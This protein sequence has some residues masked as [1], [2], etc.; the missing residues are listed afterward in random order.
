[1]RLF[2]LSN[3]ACSLVAIA[4]MCM[5]SCSDDE[6]V[7]TPIAQPSIQVTQASHNS[8]TFEWTAVD[9]AVQYGYKF[10]DSM[11]ELLDGGVTNVTSVSFTGLSLLSEYT[12]HVWAYPTMADEAATASDEAILSYTTPFFT[13]LNNVGVY[14]SAVVPNG[15]YDA[16]IVEERTAQD[17]FGT[18]T[19]KNFYG[20]EGYDLVFTVNA[21]NTINIL[22]GEADEASGMIKVMTGNS[23]VRVKSGLLIDP[24]DSYF[25]RENFELYFYAK[26]TRGSSAGYDYYAWTEE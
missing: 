11:G 9:G 4:A 13:A 14:Y 20:V 10:Y 6:V 1:M 7:K 19:I 12:L 16:T 2:R 5:A 22:N 25:D 3:I 26:A 17:R 15:S 23:N 18:I 8:L 21:D 24:A